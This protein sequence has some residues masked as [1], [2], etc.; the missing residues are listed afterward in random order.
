VSI[1]VLTWVFV[2]VAEFLAVMAVYTLVVL[3]Q[4]ARRAGG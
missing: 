4:E 2:V 3:A 1:R